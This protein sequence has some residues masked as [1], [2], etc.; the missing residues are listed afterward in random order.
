MAFNPLQKLFLRPVC[1]YPR[2]LLLYLGAPEVRQ[3]LTIALA[4]APSTQL[5]ALLA[6]V[7]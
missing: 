7:D 2:V 4:P 3:L 5:V 1:P 6:E